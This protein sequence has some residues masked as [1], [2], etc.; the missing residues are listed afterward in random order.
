M[1]KVFSYVWYIIIVPII[2]SIFWIIS[3]L[4]NPLNSPSTNTQILLT[5]TYA[6][7]IVIAIIFN[8][9]FSLK[10]KL[11]KQNLSIII[12]MI[13][14]TI[15]ILSVPLF[16]KGYLRISYIPPFKL[17]EQYISFYQEN[18][19]NILSLLYF[20]ISSL[21]KYWP[22]IGCLIISK[23][24][25][26]GTIA[27]IVCTYILIVIEIAVVFF[28]QKGFL[29]PE[30]ILINLIGIHFGIFLFKKLAKYFADRFPSIT[31]ND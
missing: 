23:N 31:L 7:L 29:A 28:R 8:Q 15:I 5:S 21:G 19:I 20:I 1:K 25:K 10:H 30:V 24:K 6:T 3:N 11:I 4:L 27:T 13:L 26:Y 12:F 16:N 2:L 22:F 17:I 14:Y 18:I 9:L